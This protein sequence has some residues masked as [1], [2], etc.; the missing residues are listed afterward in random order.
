MRI[1]RQPTIQSETVL[2]TRQGSTNI[3]EAEAGR[4]LHSGFD[5]YQNLVSENKIAGWSSF[6][7][8]I[9][10]FR[11]LRQEDCHTLEAN[12]SLTRRHCLKKW[13]QRKRD[14]KQLPF[15]SKTK[16]LFWGAGKY[17]FVC[18]FILDGSSRVIGCCV[19]LLFSGPQSQ[20]PNV[21]CLGDAPC[22]WIHEKC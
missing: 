8:V 18:I 11:R 15:I 7:F 5:T 13:A 10:M 14:Q 22:P 12:L 2:E 3:W 19:E 4:S 16:F 21:V 20:H 9:L 1:S 6:I 17:K